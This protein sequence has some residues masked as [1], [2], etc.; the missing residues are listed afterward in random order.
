[1]TMTSE[2]LKDWARL[3]KLSVE[4]ESMAAALLGLRGQFAGKGDGRKRRRGARGRG[5]ATLIIK[6]IS[7]MKHHCVWP[8]AQHNPHIEFQSAPSP[9]GAVAG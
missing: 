1:M 6:R 7:L 8:S 2:T 4:L 5:G 3:K 9:W